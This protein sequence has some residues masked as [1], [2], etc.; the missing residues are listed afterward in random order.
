MSAG[1]IRRRYQSALARRSD[2]APGVSVEQLEALAA[3]RLPEGEA[4]ALLDR[5]MAD[6][7][8]RH[9]YELLR[10]L[11]AADAAARPR[12]WLRPALA[13]AAGVTVVVTIGTLMR[14]GGEPATVRG[15]P[16]GALLALPA[17]G[18][19]ASLPTTLTWRSVPGARSYQVEILD[20][21]GAVLHT[22]ETR[23]T[24]IAVGT[25]D[26]PAGP[27][28]WWVEVRLATGA[29]RSELRTITFAEP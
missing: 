15:I 21:D 11:H 18:A 3:H 23:D 27:A 8:L 26:V 13:L 10:S 19:V 14:A 25:G 1:E 7:G 9:E 22:R 20:R 4:L 17:S 24:T 5:V 6:E 2:P 28:Q 12:R 29:D 16:G